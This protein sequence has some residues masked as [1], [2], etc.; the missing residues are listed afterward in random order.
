MKIARS[1]KK[2][3]GR[4]RAIEGEAKRFL[5]S[6][7]VEMVDALDAWAEDEKTDRSVVIRAICARA[8]KARAAKKKP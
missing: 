1:K 6:M 4:P 5:L 2:G 7:P 8:I 3:P